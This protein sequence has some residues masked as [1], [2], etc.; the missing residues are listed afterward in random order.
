MRLHAPHA[1]C[2]SEALS[3]N[4]KRKE[5]VKVRLKVICGDVPPIEG[6]I[7]GDNLGEDDIL[8]EGRIIVGQKMVYTPS[9]QEWNDHQ[10]THIPF[11]K[12]CPCCA[13]GKCATGAQNHEIR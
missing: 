10:R 2:F 12:W 4:S 9:K 7:D 11:R 1:N 3:Q 5:G 8:D 6:T 13:K